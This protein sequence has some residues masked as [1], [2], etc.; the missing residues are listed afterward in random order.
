MK[1]LHI[2]T[3]VLLALAGRAVYAQSASDNDLQR[4]A[5]Q[6]LAGRDGA[7][8]VLDPQTGRVRAVVN[9]RRAFHESF[10]DGS[11]VKPF[12]ALAALQGGAV[13]GD[14]KL[15]CA[16]PY[17]NHGYHA[18]CVHPPLLPP[19]DVSGALAQS[20]NYF[21]GKLGERFDAQTF[22][23][24]LARFG[25]S[26]ALPPGGWKAQYATG[27]SQTIRTR[28]VQLIAAY[29]ALAN[30][31]FLY[32][33]QAA[34]ANNF[35]PR[36]RSRV[37]ISDAQRSL[38]IEGMRGAVVSGTARESGLKSL[39]GYVFGK[40][41]TMLDD[42]SH[43]L[44]GWFVGLAAAGQTGDTAAPS[45][46]KLAVLVYLK[47]ARGADCAAVSREI[48]AAWFRGSEEQ[49]ELSHYRA[50]PLV[51][52][53][54]AGG[55][56]VEMPV[57]DYVMRVVAAEG[58]EEDE[59]EALK[60][61]AVAART[62][63]LKNLHRHGAAGFD[64]CNLTH[65]QR[66]F[67]I[68]NDN[69]PLR[70][71]RA[72]EATRGLSL[73]S[74][75]GA[76]IEAFYSASCG[77]MAA[78]I[79]ELWGAKRARHLRAAPDDACADGPHNRWQDTISAEKLAAALRAE[80][81]TDT[82]ARLDDIRIARRDPTGRAQVVTLTGERTRSVSGWD[83]KLIVGRNLGWN[84]LKSSR[85]EVSKAGDAYVFRGRGFGHGL[86]LCQEGAHARARRGANY[87]RILA[88]YFPGATIKRAF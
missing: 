70:A 9:E 10:P 52:V 62:Y 22:R 41:G 53:R 73:V 31:G 5:A 58:S 29:A 88:K 26:A 54:P 72:V 83:F 50:T 17:T 21:F 86:G 60:A 25:L 74:S 20:C 69:V 12:V 77:G 45:S 43:S 38:L 81:R 33:P 87:R 64:F 35:K 27:D 85:F 42:D 84:Y 37:K 19:L 79:K 48:F 51:R 40:T 59:P 61:L 7:V 34:G 30:G 75:N 28:P 6:A 67:V 24:A 4:A 76:L 71:R 56:T 1:W 14:S 23:K 39:A 11:T 32:A 57:E 63:A 47:N 68:S 65:C 36:L 46:V 55:R 80:P 18:N 49:T 13:R 82:G 44:Q 3:A 66:F 2:L 16:S 8:V 15:R 78:D